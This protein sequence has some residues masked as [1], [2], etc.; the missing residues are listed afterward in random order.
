MHKH[1]SRE[2]LI[3]GGALIALH[4]Y[5]Q[6]RIAMIR[7]HQVAEWNTDP[8]VLACRQLAKAIRNAEPIAQEDDMMWDALAYAQQVMRVSLEE[9]EAVLK[10][11]PLQSQYDQDNSAGLLMKP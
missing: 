6:E 11:T 1:P 10:I 9:W 3:V 2:G 7:S 5:E 4:G 8:R